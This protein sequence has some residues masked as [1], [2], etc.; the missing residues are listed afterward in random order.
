MPPLRRMTSSYDT[1]SKITILVLSVLTCIY[2]YV[3]FWPNQP[4]PSHLPFNVVIRRDTKANFQKVMADLRG[5]YSEYQSGE[6]HLGGM[7]DDIF[8]RSYEWGAGRKE[9]DFLLDTGG[10][11]DYIGGGHSINEEV[12]APLVPS[13]SFH[14]SSSWVTIRSEMN[15]R[16]LWMHG[17]EDTWM[18]ASATIDTPVHRKTFKLHP[19]SDC[20]D[21]WVLLQEGDGAAFA[22]MIN[23]NRTKDSFYD[24][25]AWVVKLGTDKKEVAINDPAYHFMIESEGFVVNRDCLACVNVMAEHD[26]IVRGHSSGWNTHHPAGREFGAMVHFTIINQTDVDAAIAKEQEEA[27]QDSEYDAKLVKQIAIYPSSSEKRVISFGLYGGKPK[28]TTG[29]VQNVRLA[30]TYFPGWVCRFY[31]TSDVPD[32][33][34]DQL[35]ALGAEIASVPSGK[36][37]TSGMF[38]RFMVASDD[39]VD[40]YIVRDSDSRLNARD[41]IAVEEWITSGRS[42]HIMRDHVNHCIVMNGGMWGGVKGAIPQMKHLVE[43]WESR[44]EYMADLHFLE[45]QIWPEIKH[46]QLSH[47][48]YCCDRFPHCRPFPTKRYFNYQHVGQVF[49]EL[50]RPRLTDIDGFIRGV[51]TPNSCR[52]EPEWIYG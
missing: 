19:V 25:E 28:Y 11:T 35:K 22:Y 20:K 10:Y 24:R 4:R 5:G 16:F 42:V 40:R 1:E 36:G 51:P 26:Y 33:V 30:A 13:T 39:T 38:W 12:F 6:R 47:D 18:G 27:A 31:V 23:P 8:N 41:R 45:D 17:T 32:G 9:D 34:I 44:D 29:A 3:L 50:D 37:Y 49:D 14:C 7:V 2:L 43:T 15:Y 52:K 46:K 48:S 21:G